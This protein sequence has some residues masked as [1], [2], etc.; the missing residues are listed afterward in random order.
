MVR[1]SKRQFD[2]SK[3]A[4]IVEPPRKMWKEIYE[5][6]KGV[7][8]RKAAEYYEEK[9]GYESWIED[10]NKYATEEPDEKSFKIDLSDWKYAD[11]PAGG[12]VG[13]MTIADLIESTPRVFPELTVK[14]KAAKRRGNQTVR[15]NWSPDTK[16]ITI[17][18]NPPIF[19]I[20]MVLRGDVRFLIKLKHLR[21]TIG[22]ELIHFAQD[23][24]TMAKEFAESPIA[25][26]NINQNGSLL[27][28]NISQSDIRKKS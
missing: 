10:A 18:F 4:K 17:F 9:P 16:T 12:F 19:P 23:L 22:H 21:D 25:S 1:L 24:V 26:T 13:D 5:W 11:M 28:V 6:A 14:F 27:K 20:K 3:R 2:I 7:Y 15:A 8:S